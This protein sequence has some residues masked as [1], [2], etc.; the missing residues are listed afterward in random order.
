M[1]KSLTPKKVIEILLGVGIAAIVFGA[2]WLALE[3]RFATPTPPG[4][5]QSLG[6][7]ATVLSEPMN[8]PSFTLIDHHNRPFTEKNLRGQWTFL[9]FGYTYCPDICPTALAIL[10]QAD[11][12]LQEQKAQVHPRFIFVSVD[13]AR[14]T[15]K[16]LA[17][18][19]YYFNPAFL[20]VTGSE[21]EI[22][23]LTRPLGIAYWFA[24]DKDSNPNYIVD[25]SASILLV[26]PEGQLRAITSPPHYAEAIASDYQKII[27]SVGSK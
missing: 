11:K 17:D 9:F 4:L 18:Y 16:Q 19:L 3:F 1:T 26:D 13:P 23:A 5:P 20:G 12:L 27:A 7:T 25:H 2:V 10:N 22:Q 21:V 24:E 6:T 14:D 15:A 8:V